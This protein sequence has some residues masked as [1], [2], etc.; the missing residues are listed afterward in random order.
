MLTSKNSWPV[1]NLSGSRI[2]LGP[3]RLIAMSSGV[4]LLLQTP[5]WGGCGKEGGTE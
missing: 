3:V 1:G 2:D 5:D 4:I